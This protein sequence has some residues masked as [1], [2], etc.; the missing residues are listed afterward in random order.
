M[1]KQ[2][3]FDIIYYVCVKLTVMISSIFV[4][5]LENIKFKSICM[6]QCAQSLFLF[7]NSKYISDSHVTHK[8]PIRLMPSAMHFFRNQDR[9]S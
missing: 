1:S 4:A 7:S 9:V 8:I 3:W 5:F 6:P 2:S